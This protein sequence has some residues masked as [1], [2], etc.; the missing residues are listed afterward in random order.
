[1]DWNMV[2]IRMSGRLNIIDTDRP[3]M[4]TGEH[5]FRSCTYV[6][7]CGELMQH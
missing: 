5:R 3:P 4:A 1:V 6:Q 2:T 7:R